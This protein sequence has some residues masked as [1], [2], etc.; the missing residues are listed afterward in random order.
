VE[1]FMVVVGGMLMGKE[2]TS[3]TGQM[4]AYIETAKHT[5]PD[6]NHVHCGVEWGGEGRR[7]TKEG[8]QV[9]HVVSGYSF[10]Y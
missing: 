1:G 2:S 7:N 4:L 6:Y 10:I 3:V 8:G 5:E 9:T